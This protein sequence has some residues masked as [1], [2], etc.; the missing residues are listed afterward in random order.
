MIAPSNPFD[1]TWFIPDNSNIPGEFIT[2][3]TG[4]TKYA[5]VFTNSELAAVFLHDLNDP[6]LQIV[7]LETWVLK[8][9]FL[10]AAKILGATKVM[11]DYVKGQH[12]AQSAPIEGLVEYFKTRSI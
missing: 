2:L 1:A 3:S 4:E 5:L 11:F 6:S 9:A 7:S 8:D 10:T 12:S